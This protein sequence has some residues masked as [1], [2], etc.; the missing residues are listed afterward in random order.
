ML[1]G[2]YAYTQSIIS[3]ADNDDFI[4]K[5]LLYVPLHSSNAY[6]HWQYGGWFA[7]ADVNQTGFRYLE[8][9]NNAFIEGFAL[10]NTSIGKNFRLGKHW[11]S[12]SA[13]VNNLL[14]TDYESVN[15]RAMPGRNYQLSLR[16]KFF[17][18]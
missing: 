7:Q 5:Q 4:G 14:D 17:S 16:Y 18:R 1:G 9:S 11:W 15:N 3:K 8:N 6:A 13:R 10:L 12:I 2:N